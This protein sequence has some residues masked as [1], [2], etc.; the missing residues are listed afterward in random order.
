M[1]A[2]TSWAV[3]AGGVVLTIALALVAG[4]TLQ[5][6]LRIASIAGGAAVGTGAVGF[7]LLALLRRRSTGAQ[8]TVVALASIGAVFAGAVAA[9]EA[10]FLS[11]HDLHQ[12]MVILV[13]AGTAGLLIASELGRRVRRAGR[14]LEAVAARIGDGEVPTDAGHPSPREFAELADRLEETARRL[15]QARSRERA[16][17]ASRR[18]LV[19]WVSHDLRTPLAGIRAMVEALEDGV[20]TDPVT[21]ERY[22]RNLRVEAE[23]LAALVDD[24]FELSVI[25]AGALDLHMERASLEDVVQDAVSTASALAR[26]KGVRLEERNDG[27]PIELALATPEMVRV[28]RN[29]LQNA[30]RHTPSDGTVWVESGMD[31]DRAY[32]AVADQCGGIP[33]A[34]LS[35]VFDLAFRGEAARTPGDGGGGLGLAI[36]R[37]V[38]EA[39]HGDISVRNEN[40]GCRFTVRLPLSAGG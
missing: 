31:G 9:A 13:A 22:H 17:E 21:V 30:I 1:S 34:D 29:L 4:M 10:M 40:G 5:D 20:V 12:L 38:V 2:R 26:S 6:A 32:V 19:A 18:E 27:P 7:G 25:Q 14:S 39:H 11:A 37:G 8:V 36:A 35:R 28:L 24:L 15:D 23:R 33:E 3:T 16:L